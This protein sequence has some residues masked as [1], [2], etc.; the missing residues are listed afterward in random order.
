MAYLWT[1]IHVINLKESMSFYEKVLGLKPE[2]EF[3]PSPH[4]HIAFLGNGETK[5]ELIEAS[6]APSPNYGQDLS[7]GF[8]VYSVEEM[9]HFLEKEGIPILAGP[10]SPNPGIRFLY[11]LDPNGL[12]IQLV[13]QLGR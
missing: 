8:S 12:K 6:D 5:I 2:R 13:E 11:I 3:S 4:M 9:I 7:L 10:L 1:T